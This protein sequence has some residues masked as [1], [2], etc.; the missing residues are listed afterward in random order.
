MN[1]RFC[2]VLERHRSNLLYASYNQILLFLTDELKQ[3]KSRVDH[4][5][6][7]ESLLGFFH[8]LCLLSILWALYSLIYVNGIGSRY[9]RPIHSMMFISDDFI[10]IHYFTTT[11]SKETIQHRSQH[12]SIALTNLQEYNTVLLDTKLAHLVQS[13]TMTLVLFLSF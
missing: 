13:N 4:V 6:I 8:L 1:S 2:I 5:I 12:L 7:R 11:N 3:L 9:K 10:L